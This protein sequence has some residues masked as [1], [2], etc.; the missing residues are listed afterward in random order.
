MARVS[1]RLGTVSIGAAIVGVNSW[2]ASMEGTIADATGMDSSIDDGVRSLSGWTCSA[3]GH[4]NST[5]APNSTSVYGTTV[6]AVTLSDGTISWTGNAWVT[7]L[8]I[9]VSLDGV[10]DYAYEGTGDG[11]LVAA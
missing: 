7:R 5:D 8:H 4:W 9:E 1:G 10:V 11:A 2:T 6:E 3:E